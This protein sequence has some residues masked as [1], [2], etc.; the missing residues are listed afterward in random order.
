GERKNAA[1]AGE[2]GN[3]LFGAH[4]V[5]HRRSDHA[6]LSVGGPKFLA[7]VCAVGFKVALRCALEDKVSGGREES[8]VDRTLTIDAPDFSLLRSEEHTSELQ[9]RVDLVCRLLLEKKKN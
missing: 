5:C 2:Q 1:P 3:V 9:S 7:G 4:S 8:A 6:A